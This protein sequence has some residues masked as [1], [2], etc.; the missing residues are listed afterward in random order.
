M[1]RDLRNLNEA[2]EALD[3]MAMHTTQ[4]SFV[5]VK[6]VRKLLEDR[7]KVL[8]E[9]FENRVE[10]R[11]PHKM[12]PARARRLA[13]RDPDLREAHKS[14]GPREPGKSVPA[15]PPANEGVKS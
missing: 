11:I 7:Q 4:G 9:E 13:M 2:F 15:G 10:K 1:P 12:S 3:E 6:D 8:D 14:P 5:K